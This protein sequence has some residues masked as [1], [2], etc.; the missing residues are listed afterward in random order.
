MKNIAHF[1][2]KQIADIS[3]SRE[4]WFANFYTETDVDL[5]NLS[6]WNLL[7][8]QN[9]IDDIMRNFVKS[10]FRE[11]WKYVNENI[12][13]SY[14]VIGLGSLASSQTTLFSDIEFAIIL[15]ESVENK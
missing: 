5:F 6:Y 14:W 3:K 15:G 9:R 7:R 2:L 11:S 13:S 8:N 10:L 12:P 4:E 1:L